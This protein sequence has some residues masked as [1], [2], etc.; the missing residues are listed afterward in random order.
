MS[1]QKHLTGSSGFICLPAE[2]KTSA[3][4]LQSPNNRQVYVTAHTPA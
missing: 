3:A 4:V 1:Q 2:I